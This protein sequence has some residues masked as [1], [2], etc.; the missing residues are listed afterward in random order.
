MEMHLRATN[1][2]PTTHTVLWRVALVITAGALVLLGCSLPGG[3]GPDD[4]GP[5][6]GPTTPSEGT[7][8][9]PLS[10]GSAVGSP[11]VLSGQVGDGAPSFYSAT[12]TDG[13]YY[14]IE[15]TGNTGTVDI[16]V[17]VDDAFAS[18]ISGTGS[19]VS[20]GATAVGTTLYIRI[21]ADTGVGT[22]FTLTVTEST[23]GPGPE[24]AADLGTL[25]GPIV[26]NGL[27][28][29]TPYATGRDADWWQFTVS[30]TAT[31]EIET[32]EL[33]DPEDTRI[34]LYAVDTT[35]ND[36]DYSWSGS[37]PPPY[38]ADLVEWDDDQG[39]G[40]FS[41]ITRSLPA[42][43]YVVRVDLLSSADAG[44]Y[45]LTISIP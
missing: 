39:A 24:S 23:E 38:G 36:V 13:Q 3:P 29:G 41:I 28:T 20:T 22:S 19:T 9:A 2:P 37:P 11:A 35:L 34:Y 18:Q 16:D 27:F 40:L 4:A 8:S 21:T 31:V 42:G 15:V 43:T 32:I 25:S 12:V 30:T 33:V 14:T 26:V 10:A 7:V 5:A 45:T 17:F 6:P 44:E 1:T